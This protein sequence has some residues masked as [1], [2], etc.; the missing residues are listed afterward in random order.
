[1]Y[2]N[3]VIIMN[4]RTITVGATPKRQNIKRRLWSSTHDIVVSMLV[5]YRC[6][7]VGGLIHTG[8]LVGGITWLENTEWKSQ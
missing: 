3:Q 5:A 7:Y 6:Q 2:H 1:M 4:C 8:W